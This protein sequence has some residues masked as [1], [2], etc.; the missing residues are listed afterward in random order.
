MEVKK[1][2]AAE[3]AGSPHLPIPLREAIAPLSSPANVEDAAVPI[4]ES[5]RTEESSPIS[6]GQEGSTTEE[7]WDA[8]LRQQMLRRQLLSKLSLPHQASEASPS[9]E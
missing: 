3:Q 1:N 6:S 2:A 8:V 9:K 7:H 5:T 4:A